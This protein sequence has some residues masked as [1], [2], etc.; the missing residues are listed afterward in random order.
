MLHAPC[1]RHSSTSC[2]TGVQGVVKEA[3]PNKLILKDG[4]QL[5][6][7]VCIWSTGVGPT[8]FIESLPFAKTNVG[9]LAVNSRM[10][11][12]LQEGQV[13]I[14]T[15]TMCTLRNTVL[16]THVT[17]AHA[18][19]LPRQP[20]RPGQQHLRNLGTGARHGA[21]QPGPP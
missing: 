2:S 3:Q 5:D 1:H 14:S 21:P 7:G 6:F 16:Q 9:R 11:V 20:F 13:R 4:S 17:Q 15:I 12:L 10:Q 18:S 19:A 8:P